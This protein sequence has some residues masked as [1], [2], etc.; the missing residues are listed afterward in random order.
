M[1]YN[2]EGANE[3]NKEIKI[4]IHKY[5]QIVMKSGNKGN[6][7]GAD[8]NVSTLP[9][10]ETLQPAPPTAPGKCLQCVT[11]VEEH[12]GNDPSKP[13]VLKRGEVVEVKCERKFKND[14]KDPTDEIECKKSIVDSIR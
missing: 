10:L 9:K 8:S 4:A 11:A 12:E 3:S 14:G 2:K 1:L 5:Y 6:T 7:G 13:F